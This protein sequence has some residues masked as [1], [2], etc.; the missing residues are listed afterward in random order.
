[1]FTRISR[2]KMGNK[3]YEYVRIVESYREKGKKKQRIIANLGTVN[4]LQGKADS[5]VEGLRDYCQT[6]YV[7]PGEIKADQTPIWGTILVARKLW[8][9]LRLGQ[10]IKKNCPKSK[11]GP[12]IE[13]TA[14]VLAASSLVNPSSE[15]GL[16]WWLDKSY[17]CD[18]RGKRF[19]PEWRDQVT[20]DDR[21]RVKWEQ[22]KLWYRS[23]DRLL[24]AKDAIEKDIYLELRDLFGLKVDIVFYDITSLYFEGEGPDGLAEYGKSKDGKGRNRQILLGVV[25]ASGWPVAHHVFSGNTGEVTTLAEV[26]ADLKNRFQIEKVIFVGDGIF[27]SKKK[28][29]FK[30]SY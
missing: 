1:M 6:K 9:D 4:S 7:K 10:I 16:A 27:S 5:I 3:V 26:I 24:K 30:I 29:K 11:K 21:V 17:V 13:E 23:L 28:E 12:A 20:K 19:L 22:L 15:H 14:F 18:S 2:I 25:M 8:N